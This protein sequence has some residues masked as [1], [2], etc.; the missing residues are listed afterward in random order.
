M[1]EESP[2]D[3]EVVPDPLL[4]EEVLDAAAAGLEEVTGEARVVG[5]G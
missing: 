2:G 5:M 3:D 4:E 1:L